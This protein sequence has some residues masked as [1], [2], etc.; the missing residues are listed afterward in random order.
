MKKIIGICL[1]FALIFSVLVIPASAADSAY[2]KGNVGNYDYSCQL[3][4]RRNANLA[5]T[6]IFFSGTQSYAPQYASVSMTATFM[7]E[8]GSTTSRSGNASNN[9]GSAYTTVARPSG[10]TEHTARSTHV[11]ISKTIN[12]SCSWM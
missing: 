9:N 3:I 2:Q 4:N 6:Y 12:L 8:D 5:W 7:Y 10:S 1:A 11:A